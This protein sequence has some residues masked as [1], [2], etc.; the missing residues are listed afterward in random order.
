MCYNSVYLLV[1]AIHCIAPHPTY[2][3]RPTGYP[4]CRFE[5]AF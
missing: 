5:H 3:Y 1:A 2:I 4:F